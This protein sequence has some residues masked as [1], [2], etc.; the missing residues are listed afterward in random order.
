MLLPVPVL[1]PPRQ[2]VELFQTREDG[3][4]ALRAASITVS[5]RFTQQ[6]SNL[7]H[8]L[9]SSNPRFVRCIKSNQL[10]HPQVNHTTP[11]TRPLLP[12]RSCP[13]AK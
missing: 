8:T 6:L 10:L 3:A 7:I 12:H 5:N 1:V 13:W 2:I 4:T 9:E 11:P